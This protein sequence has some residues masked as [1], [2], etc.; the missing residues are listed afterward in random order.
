MGP[1]L[2]YSKMQTENKL[3]QVLFHMYMGQDKLISL[4]TTIARS[5]NP[6]LIIK[7]SS[8]F[9]YSIFLVNSQTATCVRQKSLVIIGPS[10]H[11]SDPEAI[12]V[13][14][15]CQNV[16]GSES[17]LE[18][19]RP[20]VYSLPTCTLLENGRPKTMQDYHLIFYNQLEVLKCCL[21]KE[22]TTK[23]TQGTQ[24]LTEVKSSGDNSP[25]NMGV[26]LTVIQKG[27]V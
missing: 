4:I 22:E 17:C 26:V 19:S 14:Q 16:E 6:N 20:N 23:M 21:S 5:P 24:P 13:S 2:L 9:N 8:C 1:C 11:Q 18:L 27:R 15:L 25:L 3:T 12:L 10:T 7:C